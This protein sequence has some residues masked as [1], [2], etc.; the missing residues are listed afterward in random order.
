MKSRLVSFALASVVA[1]VGGCADEQETSAPV[2]HVLWTAD[3]MPEGAALWLEAERVDGAIAV[4][5]WGSQLGGVFGWSAHV[6]GFDGALIVDSAIVDERL[7]AAD[8]AMHLVKPRPTDVALG[9]TRL[10]PE[11]GE[12]AI[13]D[14]TRLGELR[15]ST[16]SATVS[17]IDVR[18]AIVRRADRSYVSVTAAGGEL[19][20][21]GGL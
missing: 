13:D 9:G 5:L 12:V 14:R 15:L 3:A 6:A 18:Q 19:D 7:G 10:G 16:A 20:T 1:L 8:E 2:E 4:T 21:Q 11:L 17:R